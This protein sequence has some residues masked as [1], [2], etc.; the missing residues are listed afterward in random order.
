MTDQKQMDSAF[1]D[2]FSEYKL[3]ERLDILGYGSRD[4]Y[5]DAESTI[6]ESLRIC[7]KRI[8]RHGFGILFGPRPPIWIR[9]SNGCASMA[10]FLRRIFD[11]G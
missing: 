4:A 6:A 1:A 5:L 2:V 3:E 9:R 7:W 10:R 8:T 11:L